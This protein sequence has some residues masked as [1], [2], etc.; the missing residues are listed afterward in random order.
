MKL[1]TQEHVKRLLINSSLSFYAT[2]SAHP[3]LKMPTKWFSHTLMLTAKIN[4][5]ENQHH[6]FKQIQH[7]IQQTAASKTK[8][9]GLYS[10]YN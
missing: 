4:L 6:M 1:T 5:V 2:N 3:F 8:Y 9:G 10:Q 7:N